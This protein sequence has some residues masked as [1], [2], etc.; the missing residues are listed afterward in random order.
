MGNIVSPF[1]IPL[2]QD[3]ISQ[4]SYSLIKKDVIEYLDKNQNSL[5]TP[6][7]CPTK[8]SLFLPQEQ[9]FKSKNIENEVKKITSEYIKEWGFTGTLPLKIYGMWV[10]V[11]KKGSFQ[12]YHSHT[13][14]THQHLFSGT[15]YIDAD[16]NSGDL[17]LINPIDKILNNIPGSLKVKDK[18]NIIPQPGLIVSFPS[19]L[20]HYV[21]ENKNNTNRISVSWNVII[22]N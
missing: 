2:F 8:T 16:K 5:H 6:W 21:G 1:N 13:S 14:S 11:S 10:N 3:I 17:F 18:L 7:D 19:F 9:N 4:E 15:L 22:N 20:G 12:E